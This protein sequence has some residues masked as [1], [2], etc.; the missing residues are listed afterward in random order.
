MGGNEKS[1]WEERKNQKIKRHSL[2]PGYVS[3]VEE[4]RLGEWAGSGVKSALRCERYTRVWTHR[5]LKDFKQGT[6]M[7][8]LA[9]WEDSPKFMCQVVGSP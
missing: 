6:H 9:H 5:S 4:V 2:R 7:T 3:D 1:L 8:R